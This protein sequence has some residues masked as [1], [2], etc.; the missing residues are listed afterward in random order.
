M[1]PENIPL[2]TFHHYGIFQA[3]NNLPCQKLVKYIDLQITICY[4]FF[5]VKNIFKS[6]KILKTEVMTMFKV[7]DLAVYPAHGVGIIQSIEKKETSGGKQIFYIIKIVETGAIIMLPISNIEAVGLRRVVDKAVLPKVYRILKNK[8]EPAND[9]QTWNRRYREYMEKIKSG[10]VMEVASVMR[11]LHL[12]K[13]SKELSFGERK[14]LDI[15]KG[16]LVKELAIT[17]NI[18]EGKMEKELNKIMQ[19]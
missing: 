13:S 17:K 14:M 7:G 12:L 1:P 6:P 11:E 4:S 3:S 8:K 10:C 19:V 18:A 9:N 2:T 15:A 16:L 5:T